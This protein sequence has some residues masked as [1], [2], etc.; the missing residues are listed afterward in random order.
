M[1]LIL[2]VFFLAW[3]IPALA[4]IGTR[5][6]EK[7]K[8]VYEYPAEDDVLR[9]FV[10]PGFVTKIELPDDVEL[11]LV[12]D[13]DLLKV[14]VSSDKRSVIVNTL[15]TEGETNLIVDTASLNLN[16]EVIIG[17]KDKVDYRVWIDEYKRLRDK[18]TDQTK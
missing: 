1:R 3:S 16:Y 15:S 11:V 13:T 9:V 18:Q 5:Y 17:D 2:I 14:E 6:L 4:F 10:S 8:I 12:G 7:G